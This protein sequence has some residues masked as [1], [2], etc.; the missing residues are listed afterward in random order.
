MSTAIAVGIWFIG[1]IPYTCAMARR[2]IVTHHAPDLDAVGAVWILKR[3]DSQTYADAKVAFVNPGEQIS[4]TEAEKYGCQLHEVTHVDTGLGEFDHHQPDRGL[5]HIS[6]T[7]LVYDHILKRYPDKVN[8]QALAKIVE[9]TTD[10][11]HFGE[12]SWPDSGHYR[13]CFMIQDLINGM[14]FTDPHNDDSQLHFGLQ[15]LDNAYASLTQFLKAEEIL[16][17][18][19]NRFELAAG[20]ALAIETNNDQT[21]KLAQKRGVALV[22]RKDPDEGHIRIKARPDV[23][24]ELK[25]L[26]DRI[27]KLDP[28][29]TW[30]YHPSGKMLINGSR[31]HRDQQA[32]SLSLEQVTQL[33]QE[34][35]G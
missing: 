20:S 1:V 15:C 21:I 17:S 26:A 32:S 19:G 13:H 30:Y 3:F 23:D 8:D 4:L 11:D 16:A 31:K 28:K 22:I 35:Y 5:Q 7:S 27:A 25:P 33:V 2:L 29:A 9:F 14:E 6:A 10:V 12:V 34:L 18:R 24:I